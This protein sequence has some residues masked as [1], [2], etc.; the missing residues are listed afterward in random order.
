MDTFLSEKKDRFNIDLKIL[1]PSILISIIGIVTLLSTTILPNGTFGDRTI[2]IRQI[3]FILIGYCL[4]FVMTKI[5]LSYTKYWQVILPIYIG[6]LILLI[7]VLVIGPVIN[8]VQRWLVIGGIQIQPSEFAKITVVFLTAYILSQKDKYNQW[9]LLIVSLLLV[10]PIVILV[11][12]E[13]DGSMSVLLLMIWFFVAFT[14]LDNQLRNTVAMSI[15]ILGTLGFLISAI[16]GNLIWLLLVLVAL[17][18]SIFGFYHRDQWRLLIII[19]FLLSILLGIGSGVVWDRVLKDYQKERIEVFLD[20]TKDTGDAGFNVNQAK[21]AIGS[22]QIW[23]KGFGNGTQSKR[24]FL[25]EY[26]TDFIFASFAEE[27]GLVGSIFLLMLLSIII[28]TGL[29]KTLSLGEEPFYA[30]LMIGFTVKLLL[31]VFINIGTNTG[32]IPATGIPLPLVS[33]GGSSIIVTLFSLGV[34]QSIISHSIQVDDSE[35]LVQ[36]YEN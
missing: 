16:V 29:I 1:I 21:I 13:P 7:L 11:Y 19:S 6:T 24:S 33:A 22:G 31:E 35:Q 34:I 15:I 2:V 17:I 20:P 8:N 10:L 9:V 18:V 27:F 3:I 26:R 12:M 23:G 28:L 4:Y 32:V 14:G 5:D 36:T 30:M 25:P